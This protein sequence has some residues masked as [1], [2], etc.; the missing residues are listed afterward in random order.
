MSHSQT[1][2]CEAVKFTFETRP[3]GERTPL[4]LQSTKANPDNIQNLGLTGISLS[5]DK[6]M[7]KF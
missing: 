6:S 3:L 1:Q 7:V 4:L 5:E 2:D